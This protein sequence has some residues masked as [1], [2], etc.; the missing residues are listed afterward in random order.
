MGPRLG[1]VLVGCALALGCGGDDDPKGSPSGTGGSGGAAGG[2]GGGAGA[3]GSGA[4][5]G[6]GQA[7]P[8]T[9]KRTL[10][11]GGAERWFVLHLP[12]SYDPSQPTPL[13]LN[14]H[15]R[16][17]ETFGEAAPLQQS[18]S[19][20]P[21][22]ADAAGFILVAPQGLK[23]PD[24]NQTW[25]AGL[26]CAADK[27]RDDVG[28]VDAILDQLES[29]LCVDASR[30]FAT[31]LSNGGFMSHRL[32]CERAERIAAVAPVAAY[33]GMT[34]CA[35]SRP[36]SLI[37]FNGTA[38]VLVSHAIALEH[39]AA[40]AT[41][42]GCDASAAQTF[43]NGDSTC[44]TYS[45]CDGGAEVVQCSVDDGGHTWPG[46]IDL[47]GFGKTTQDLLAN[48]AMWEFFQKHPL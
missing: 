32:A 27:S 28:F 34:S 26:C 10:T 6:C 48:D 37:A 39:S 8:A 43:S 4:Q 11:F 42:N 35:P 9:G 30:V 29:E 1:L 45:G 40:W 38:D 44:Q 47:P 25:N 23:D 21:A 14:F 36:I 24:G 7:A 46:G 2:S 3:G 16:T 22:K 31:G 41:R 13:V 12:P 33:N 18:L 20:L 17:A 15:G 19:K 5:S